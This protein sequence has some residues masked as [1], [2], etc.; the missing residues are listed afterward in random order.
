M[1][2]SCAW[3]RRPA[4]SK[5]QETLKKSFANRFKDVPDPA[6]KTVL[7]KLIEIIPAPAKGIIQER[8]KQS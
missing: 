3:D 5:E 1:C 2:N 4:T 7:G 8:I 6:R